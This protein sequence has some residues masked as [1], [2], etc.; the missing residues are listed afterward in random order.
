VSTPLW[1]QTLQT[2]LSHSLSDEAPAPQRMTNGA[3]AAG[4]LWYQCG[5]FRQGRTANLTFLPI[6]ISRARVGA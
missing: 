6:E 4:R 3:R 1:P 5:A 2:M